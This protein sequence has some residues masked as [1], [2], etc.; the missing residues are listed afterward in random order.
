[1]PRRHTALK[2]TLLFFSL[3]LCAA[4][5]V[6]ADWMR[7]SAILRAHPE[8]DFECLTPDPVREHALKENCSTIA[9]WGGA[10]FSFFTNNLGFR[11][12]RVRVVPPVVSKP[13][14]LI[15]GDSFT[16]GAGNWEQ[17]YVGMLAARMPQY[18]FLNGGVSSYSP[19]NYLNTARMVMARGISFDEA[20][21][22][23]DLSDVQDEAAFYRD[24]GGSGAVTGPP[25]K[26]LVFTPLEQRRQWIA[27]H[28]FLTNYVLNFLQG[29]LVK[30][31]YYHL[32]TGL[33]G[34]TLDLDRSAWSY[35]SV[36]EKDEFY[37]TGSGYGPLGVN[38]GIAREEARMTMLWQELAA[39]GIPLSVVVYP[40]PAQLAH[41]TVDSRQ[42]RIWRDW[43]QG[44]CKR[45]VSLFPTFVDLKDR[46]HWFEPGCW[47]SKYFIFGD[48]H[49]N[50]RGNAVVAAVVAHALEAD[51]VERLPHAPAAQDPPGHDR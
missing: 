36:D 2:L 30:F 37:P 3:L 32:T 31:G 50:A 11:D 28:L 26:G 18:D 19:S 8:K 49:Y 27:G 40:W 9:H 13:R 41:D 39:R 23:I 29:V 38:G 5:F 16:Q 51:P 45:F 14:V 22:F 47:Y 43:C 15:L 44:K 33:L 17:T 34:D 35:R 7:T 12:S 10:S 24:V 25:Q 6:A 21:V 48:V 20:I 42:V 1:L 46:C 4:L